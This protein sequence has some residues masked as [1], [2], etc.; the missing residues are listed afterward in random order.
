LPREPPTDRQP[1]EPEGEE[2]DEGRTGDEGGD[3]NSGEGGE[4]GGAIDPGVLADSSRATEQDAADTGDEEGES[5]QENGVGQFLAEKFSDCPVYVFGGFTEVELGEAAQ[6]GAVLLPEG[7]VEVVSCEFDGGSR[8]A[9]F[10]TFKRAALD[11]AHHE[12]GD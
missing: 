10:F 11:G 9:A 8:S 2:S 3:G 1:A 4:H 6:V 12:E 7:A 5:A